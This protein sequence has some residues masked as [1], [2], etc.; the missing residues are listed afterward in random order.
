MESAEIHSIAMEFLT[1]PW[2][3]LLFGKDTE[4][5][6]LLHAEDSFVFLAYGCACLLYTSS[7]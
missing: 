4:K 6:A 5:Y 2:H 1:A 7:A 3:H